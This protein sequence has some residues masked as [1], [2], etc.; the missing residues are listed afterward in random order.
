[1]GDD[2]PGGLVGA[3]IARAEPQVLRLS[4]TYTLADGAEAIDI[5][6]LEAAWAVWQYC[7]D[8]VQHLFGQTSG[9]PD[10]DKLLGALHT[11]PDG[12]DR[13]QVSKLFTGHRS[14]RQLDALS[15]R[16]IDAA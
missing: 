15:R 16:L 9:D 3:L 6:H 5:P 1:M 8:S 11:A 10:A 12:L 14:K 2:D 13:T 7:R 4:L